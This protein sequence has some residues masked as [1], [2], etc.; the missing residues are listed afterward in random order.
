MKDETLGFGGDGVFS[1]GSFEPVARSTSKQLSRIKSVAKV[2][3]PTKYGLFELYGFENG[4]TPEVHTAL[5][6]G[7]VRGSRD[8]PVRV[9]SECHTGDVFG[10]LRCDCREQL[11]ASIEYISGQEYGAVLYMR[12]EG[13]G[14]GLS[15]K[16]KAY[17]L[18]D[19]GFDTVEANELLGLPAEAR[20][21][22]IAAEIIRYLGM[23]SIVLLTNNPDKI[24]KLSGEGIEITG[25]HPLVIDANEHNRRYLET[26]KLRMRHLL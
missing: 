18:Q 20:T 19:S 4:S 8:C 22:D 16:L 1:E 17:S 11:E 2:K 25:R 5:V 3:F 7:N 26:K 14:I 13:R 9:H 15:N 24:E 10:S 6:K 21:Y 23:E 12:Q